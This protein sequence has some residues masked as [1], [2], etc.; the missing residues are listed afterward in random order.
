MKQK[1]EQEDLIVQYFFGGLPEEEKSR[2]EERFLTDN[3][4]FQQM[5]SV[6]DA[7]IDAYV[8]EELS[9]EDREKVEKFLLPAHRRTREVNFVKDLISDLGKAGFGGDATPSVVEGPSRWNSLLMSLGFRRSRKQFSFALILFAVLGLAL[10]G[11]NIVLQNR[12][13]RLQSKQVELEIEDRRLQ[14]ELE[15]EAEK[16]QRLSQDVENERIRRER[17]EQELALQQRPDTAAQPSNIATLFLPANSFLRSGGELK[18]MRLKPGTTQLNIRIEVN[19]EDN[20]K[21][22]SAVLKT[23][24]GRQVWSRDNIGPG[25]TNPGFISLILPAEI[26]T[27]QDYTLTLRGHEDGE[28]STDIGDYSFRIKK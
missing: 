7:L 13:A 22:Y 3:E 10:T 17:I 16:N 5:L 1:T 24:E 11:W 18:L 19:K 2:V 25:R 20:F 26:L 4:F 21:S 14:Q 8:Q 6:E 27:N 12:I 28:A 9:P 23:F 15:K